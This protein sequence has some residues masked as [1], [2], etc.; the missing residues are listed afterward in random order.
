MV[1]L[2]AEVAEPVR[3]ALVQPVD[4]LVGSSVVAEG[5]KDMA[6]VQVSEFKQAL[7]MEASTDMQWRSRA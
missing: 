2:R 4:Q 6:K 7:D 5:P 3:K 1:A